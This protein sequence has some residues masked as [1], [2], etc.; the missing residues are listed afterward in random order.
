MTTSLLIDADIVAYK[1]AA[2]AQQPN[3]FD[4]DGDPL[5]EDLGNVTKEISSYLDGLLELLDAQ[6][7][8]VCLSDS[9]N[10]RK[11]VLPSY[12]ANRA[13]LPKPVLLGAVR[14]WIEQYYPCFKRPWLEAD[15]VMGILST[16]RAII[17]HRKIIVSEALC[18]E[19]SHTQGC[20]DLVSGQHC[21]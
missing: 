11:N 10:F 18:Q 14:D 9:R 17:P 6:N 19:S 16:N 2:T 7:L 1:F 20:V 13:G 21:F 15:D 8:V 5:V 3:P 12:K 4:I